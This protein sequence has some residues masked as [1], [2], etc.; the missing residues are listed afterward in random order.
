MG[1]ELILAGLALGLAA[2][3]WP[4][5]PRLRRRRPPRQEPPPV[6][7]SVIIPAR[8]EAENLPRLM[9]SLQ[10]QTR[11]PEEI[12]V[13]DDGSTDGTASVAAAWGARVIP[14][15]P[16]PEGWRGKPWA[17]YQ[18]ARAAS[19]EWLLFLDADVWLE[20]DGLASLLMQYAGG[21]MSLVPWHQVQRPYEHL[22]LFFNLVMVLSGSGETLFGQM[23]LVDRESYQ[24]V[25]GHAS[26]KQHVLENLWLTFELR[27]AGIPV[28]SGVGRGILA[29]RMYPKGYRQMVEGWSKGFAGGAA[30]V[31]MRTR[32]LVGAWLGGL[33]TAVLGFLWGEAGALWTMVYLAC[34]VQVAWMARQVGDFHWA[35]AL[36]YPVCLFVFFG[37]MARSAWFPV[38][39]VSWKGRRLRGV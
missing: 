38:R 19:G 28:S 13:V 25:G 27:R 20:P 21:A 15:D 10:T 2:C 5:Q 35:A 24:R 31:A 37:I 29:M 39:T 7:L 33:T 11:K 32:I 4:L 12:L 14:S 18:G 23:L 30:G 6:R 34:A 8:N 16:L 3:A 36:F 9:R 26:V 17:C 22:S 1:P